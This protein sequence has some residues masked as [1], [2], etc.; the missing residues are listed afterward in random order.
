MGAESEYQTD[1]VT[2]GYP[3]GTTRGGRKLVLQY[4]E[5]RV[6][7]T[8]DFFMFMAMAYRPWMMENGLH[9]LAAGSQ[10]T[11]NPGRVVH[12]W[13]IGT[14]LGVSGSLF[15]GSIPDALGSYVS[16]QEFHV[17]D[18]TAY[19]PERTFAPTWPPG[20]EPTPGA[21]GG[22]VYLIDTID[23]TPGRMLGFVRGKSELLVPLLTH[24]PPRAKEHA[25]TLIASG[26]L[27]GVG[28]PSAVNL[29]Q[30][31]SSNTLLET[32][33]RIGENTDYQEFVQTCVRREDQHL[34]GPIDFYDPRPAHEGDALRYRE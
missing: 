4:L 21:Q 28:A 23:V 22:R 30:L 29:W 5:L 12:L 14:P 17:L 15:E 25:W 31:P 27:H 20:A 3:E 18:A 32:M 11:G 33:L 34:L 7:K 2:W 1:P 9:L 16:R 24:P 10:I 8:L 19:D 26:W 13:E 6:E